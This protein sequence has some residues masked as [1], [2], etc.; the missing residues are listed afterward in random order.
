MSNKRY[1]SI[2]DII[3][4]LTNRYVDI[5]DYDFDLE[6]K[7]IEDESGANGIW[8]CCGAIAESLM[9]R[10]GMCE[11]IQELLYNLMPENAKNKD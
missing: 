5:N 8:D 4:M 3:Y 1:E 10:D 11:L 6:S 2:R 7:G 9:H